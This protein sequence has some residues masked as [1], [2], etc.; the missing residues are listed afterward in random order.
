LRVSSNAWGLAMATKVAKGIIF[1]TGSIYL[2]HRKFKA[3]EVSDGI[4]L[5][6]YC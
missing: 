2:G 1:L 6:V 4:N 3:V 5:H